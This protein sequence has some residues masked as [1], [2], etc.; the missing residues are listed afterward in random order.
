MA[1]TKNSNGTY[2]VRISYTNDFGVR[3]EKKKS[4]FVTKTLAAHWERQTLN[5]IENGTIKAVSV[6]ITLDEVVTRWLDEFNRGRRQVTV[7]R[8]VHTFNNH[9]LTTDW[10]K[11]VK[12]SKITRQQIQLWLNDIAGKMN[13]YKSVAGYFK[14]VLDY[15]VSLEY[16]ASNP[17]DNVRY[18]TPIETKKYDRVDFYDTKQ[19]ETFLNVLAT[20]YDTPDQLHK[21]TF[22]RTLAVSGMRRN[23][24][25]AITWSDLH[26][27]EPQ[28]YINVDKTL[29]VDHGKTTV[30]PPKTD[31]GA[32]TVYIDNK[33]RQL[34][35][36]LRAIQGKDKMIL[37]VTTDIVF[38]NKTLTNYLDPSVP[39][40]WLLKAIEGTNLPTINIHGLRKSYVTAQVQAG[41]G[42]KA[43]QAQIGHS[44]KDVTTLL[45]VYAHVTDEMR[46]GTVQG[47]A[48]VIN[49]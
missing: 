9:I 27:D 33:T 40:D 42:F 7:D 47:L 12:L 45:S 29:S 37:N 14:K 6:S 41:L 34:F 20:K 36:R 24:L 15:A 4:G 10:F 43:L 1:I 22:L 35:L 31:A 28:A 16:L 32:R 38:T 3:K 19:L 5:D 30:N 39:R 26:L 21:Q 8:V 25:R 48:S 18:P 23:E 49:L 44:D 17:F 11:G 46:N 13:T 2:S